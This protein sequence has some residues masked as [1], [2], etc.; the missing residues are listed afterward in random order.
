MLLAHLEESG[1]HIVRTTI[2]HNFRA[3]R[4]QKD[5]TLIHYFTLLCDYC[6]QLIGTPQD[7]SDNEMR[8]H[9]YNNQPEQFSTM[10]N[11]LENQIPLPIVQETMDA[12]R[13]DQQAAGLTMQRGDGVPG[14]S[15][16]SCGHY[17]EHGG[18][19]GR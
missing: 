9:I 7:I 16:L 2:Q 4:L 8:K 11:I 14:S 18:Y 19:R 10:S 5:Q 3:C 15:L 17:L 13:R 1:T 12:L 6:I